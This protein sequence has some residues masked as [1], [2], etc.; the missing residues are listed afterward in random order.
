MLNQNFPFNF[1]PTNVITST[2]GYV[3]PAGQY[4]FVSVAVEKGESFILNGTTIM[5][6][7]ADS[8][9]AVSIGFGANYVVPAGHFFEGTASA[10]GSS[11][12]VDGNIVVNVGDT[13]NVK[14]GPGQT[15]IASA[16]GGVAGYARETGGSN[17]TN[18]FWLQPGDTITGN[19]RL[20][21]TL[22]QIP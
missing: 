10:I 5:S 6:P 3:I 18:T 12:T 11:V 15:I 21:V 9:V 16:S 7:A 2:A 14:A 8:L 4:A 17:Q 20:V 22:Y 19:A 13:G 1:K